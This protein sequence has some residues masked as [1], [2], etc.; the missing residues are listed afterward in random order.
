MAERNKLMEQIRA[1]AAERLVKKL[2]S[3]KEEYAKLL[4]ALIL[5][6]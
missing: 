1:E 4:K 5:Q 2:S 3:N 6:V